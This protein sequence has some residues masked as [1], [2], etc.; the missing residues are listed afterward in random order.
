MLA[1]TG[2][3]WGWIPFDLSLEIKSMIQAT[4]ISLTER[5]NDRIAWIGNPRGIFYLKSAYSIA[6]DTDFT[7]PINASWIWK[8]ETLPSWRCT[9]NSI[10]AKTCLAKRGIIDE[11]WC[12]IYKRDSETILHALRGCPRVK[13][14]WIQPGVKVLNRVFWMKNLQEWLNINE[15]INSSY[16]QG[17]PPWRIIFSFVVW[18]IWK[19]KNLC[20]FN[21]KDQN[22]HLSTKIENQAL[23][24]MYCVTSPRNPICKTNRRIWWEK[25]PVGWKKLNTD[26]SSMDSL[27]RAGCGGI[28][29]DEHVGWVV[30]FTRHI[31]STNNF[32]SEL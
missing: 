11:D 19:S 8:S 10:G 16:I 3:D 30:G 18:S 9:H 1:N 7:L 6:I 13:E 28:V 14:V 20:V 24:F 5:G 27:E 22:P 23:E 2:W 4:P 12:P 29:R 25:P 26:G 21:R 15:K 17:K 31:G 32:V